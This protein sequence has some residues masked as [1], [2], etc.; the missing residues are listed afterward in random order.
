MVY[1]GCE[2]LGGMLNSS[3]FGQHIVLLLTLDFIFCVVCL[4]IH[5]EGNYSLLHLGLVHVQY[6]EPIQLRKDHIEI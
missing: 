6:K 2:D 1:M 4:L 3:K 5:E